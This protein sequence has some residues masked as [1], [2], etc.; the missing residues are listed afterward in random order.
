MMDLERE[1]DGLACTRCGAEPER[2]IP[3]GCGLRGQLFRCADPC[4]A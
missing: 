4:E 1:L 3:D 2:M